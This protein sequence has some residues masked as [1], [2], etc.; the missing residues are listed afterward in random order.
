M[1]T[2]IQQYNNIWKPENKI[3]P[4]KSKIVIYNFYLFGR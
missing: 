2:A 4:L 3:N 1:L